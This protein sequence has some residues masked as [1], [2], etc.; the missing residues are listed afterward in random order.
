M[1]ARQ[2]PI[3][4]LLCHYVTAPPLSLC[5][6]SRRS[7]RKKRL[8]A[9]KLLV[10]KRSGSRRWSGSAGKSPLHRPQRGRPQ[11]VPCS[12]N[13][14]RPT[15]PPRSLHQRPPCRQNPRPHSLQGYAHARAHAPG[16]AVLPPP[17]GGLPWVGGA[18][19][20]LPCGDTG[21]PTCA[22]AAAEGAHAPPRPRPGC[23][24]AAD[25]AP[26]PPQSPYCTVAVAQAPAASS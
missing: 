25:H 21:G 11:S 13:S 10:R 18:A 26:Q 15:R 17:A 20:D 22:G 24:W 1:P 7:V 2:C 6:G 19:L 9:R 3:S 16:T 12:G 4:N 23:A 5:A 14:A 8:P